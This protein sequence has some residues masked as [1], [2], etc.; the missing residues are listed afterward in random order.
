M[1]NLIQTQLPVL[2]ITS[3]EESAGLDLVSLVQVGKIEFRPDIGVLVH[4]YLT[5]MVAGL[6][7]I[8]SYLDE[9]IR[10]GFNPRALCVGVGGGALVSFLNAKLGFEVVG[11][12]AD[13]VV[14][15]VARQYFG[16]KDGEFVRVIVGD[17]VK[18]IEMLAC[19]GREQNVEVLGDHG[20]G[21]DRHLANVD[22]L[23][24]K[25]DVVMVD[26]D[27]SDAR[28]SVT[29]PPLEFMRKPVFQAAKCVLHEGGILVI[30]V[31][32]PDQSFYETVVQDLQEVFQ[33]LYE[34]DV[35][36]EENFVLI[37][38]ASPIGAATGGSENS[39]LRKLRS[40]ISGAYMESIMKT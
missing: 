19:Q 32:P 26:L 7:L 8:A 23:D 21:K 34:I 14:L 29:A 39:F 30:N 9:R 15:R 13:E 18:L 35:G 12:E 16:L 4:P 40:V 37:A 36:N 25:F 17:G 31:I 22:G 27:S 28:M 2:P 33:E 10:R 1:P 11:V 20:V 6:A 5:P 38:T 3:I 24:T